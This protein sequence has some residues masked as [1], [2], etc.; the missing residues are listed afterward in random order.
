VRALY[1]YV[2]GLGEGPAAEPLTCLREKAGTDAGKARL[3]VALCRSQ[4]IPTRL[5]GGLVLE[6]DGSQPL[7][8]WAEAWLNNRWLPMDPARHRSGAA[9]FDDYLVLQIGDDVI[10]GRGARVTTSFTATDLHNSLGS[11]GGAPPSLAKRAWRKLSLANLRPD[12]Q[13]WV[14]F[15]LL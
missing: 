2:A 3:L 9:H 12:E 8:L 13:V 5:L 14:K 10:R 7:H 1:D 15:L 6:H 4:K 11:T